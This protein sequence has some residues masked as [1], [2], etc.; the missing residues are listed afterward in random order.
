MS[1]IRLLAILLS[2]IFKKTG[3]EKT[4]KQLQF[5]KWLLLIAIFIFGCLIKM[6]SPSNFKLGRTF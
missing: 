5:Y 1:R 3:E 4:Q 6:T 2:L